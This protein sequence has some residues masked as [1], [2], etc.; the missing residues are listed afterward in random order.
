[1]VAEMA[2]TIQEEIERWSIEVKRGAASLAILSLLS[3]GRAHGYEITKRL[4]EKTS[5]LSLEQGTVYP[6]L[7]RMEKRKLLKSEWNKEEAAKPRKY[8]R[9]TSEGKS[10]LIVMRN[11]WSGLS[12][13]MNS[14]LEEV[15]IQ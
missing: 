8:Y 7:R 6:L 4:S 5:F 10:A 1:M 3:K 13:E 14:I 12:M 11:T 15:F 2:Q 9:L